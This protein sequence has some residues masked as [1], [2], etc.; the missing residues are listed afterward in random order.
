[1]RRFGGER[2]GGERR[3]RACA[4]RKRMRR[5]DFCLLGGETKKRCLPKVQLLFRVSLVVFFVP[6]FGTVVSCVVALFNAALVLLEGTTREQNDDDD[7]DDDDDAWYPSCRRG[8]DEREAEEEDDD[9]DEKSQAIGWELE[10]ASTQERRR[11]AAFL[12]KKTKSETE[13]R[14]FGGEER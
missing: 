4:L 13:T 5:R 2:E 7:D 10:C 3:F 12:W 8:V 1:M 6:F 11:R 14:F 9:D